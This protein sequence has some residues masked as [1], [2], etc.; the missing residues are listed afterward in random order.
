MIQQLKQKYP[1]NAVCAALGCPTSS[2]YYRPVVKDEG[3]LSLP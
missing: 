2:A 3:S 1:V